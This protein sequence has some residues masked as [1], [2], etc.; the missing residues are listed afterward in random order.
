[1]LMSS[2]GVDGCAVC[3]AAAIVRVSN[4][5]EF[6]FKDVVQSSLGAAAFEKTF[7]FLPLQATAGAVRNLN[8][9]KD[10]PQVDSSTP[11]L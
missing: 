7:M 6:G 11:R 4:T 2:W 5:N 9:T 10:L 8:P 3:R 1:M